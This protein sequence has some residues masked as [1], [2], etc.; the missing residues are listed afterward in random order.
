[1]R[2]YVLGLAGLLCLAP[3]GLASVV[4]RAAGAGT[5]PPYERLLKGADQRAADELVSRETRAW[6][7]G[8]FEEAL[9][10]A[11]ALLALRQKV[12]GQAHWQTL[13]AGEE[14]EALRRTLKQDPATRQ[15][16][17]GQAAL[18]ARAAA[19]EDRG[20]YR[21][22]EPLRRQVLDLCRRALG[23]DHV[24]T[25]NAYGSLAFNLKAQGKYTA[26]EPLY[27]KELDIDLKVLGDQHPYTAK[28]YTSLGETLLVQ[29][30]HTAAE[31]LIRKALAIDLRVLGEDNADTA[32]AYTTLG[33]SL[34]LRGN[35]AAAQPLM[36][37]A[38]AINRKLLGDNHTDTAAAYNNLAFTLDT[39]GKHAAA[40]PLY[41]KALAT[42]RKVH[43]EENAGTAR[44]CNNLAMNL[45]AQ[46]KYAAAEE[47]L[48]RALA[49]GRKLLGD[50]HPDVG[51][52]YNNL[53]VDLDAQGSYAAAFPL[54]QRGLDIHRKALGEEHL[55]TA[56]CY[57][58][59]ALNLTNQGDYA[60]AEPLYQ[61]A[62]DIARKIVGEDHP[63]LGLYFNGQ[64]MNLDRQREHKTA[65]PLLRKALAVTRK[66]WGDDH[67]QTATGYNNLAV[68]LNSQHKPAEAEPLHRRAL[69]I[70]QKVLGD[71]H[72]RTAHVSAD[73]AY[74]LDAQGKFTAA[75]PLLRHAL[76][77]RRKSLG[78]EHL[79]TALGYDVLAL[80]LNAQGKYAEAE[81]MWTRAANAFQRARLRVA[82]SGLGRAA[83]TT[84]R[85]PLLFL[86]AVLARNGKPEE[87]W[88]R[89]EESLAPGTWDDLSARLHRA[90][91]D[92]D[93]RSAL[94]ASLNR[95]DQ[96]IERTLAARETADLKRRR[97]EL[98]TERRRRQEELDTLSARLENEYGPVAG[99]VY[100]RATIQAAL[101]AD[102]A[103]VGWI[104][105]RADPGAADPR[106]EH[107]AVALRAR[108]TPTWVRIRG[109]GP[110]GAWTDA[111][112]RLS[113]ALPFARPGP[114]P[115]QEP[116]ERLGKQR[117]QP[118]TAALAARDGMPRVRRLI[119]L[120]SVSLDGAPLDVCIPGYTISYAPSGTLFAYLRRQRPTAGGLL[121][122]ADPVFTSDRPLALQDQA[123][124][125]GTADDKWPALPGTR[126]E[127]EGLGQLCRAAKLPFR[128]L[129][130]SDASEQ[131]LDR[132][133]RS[134]ELASYRY[135]HLATHGIFDDSRPLQSAVILAR[136]RL[137]D[138]IKQLE[139]GRPVYDGR[140]TAEE[141]LQHWDLH[142]DLVTLSACQTALGEHQT[143][144][145]FVGFT[146]ALLLSGARSVCLS[147]W[148]VDDTATALLMQRFY[149]NLL[150]QRPGLTKPLGKAEALVE[151]KRWLRELTA[152]EA[153][154]QAAALTQGVARG[155]GRKPLPMLPAAKVHATG[156]AAKPYAHPYYWAAFVLVG[157]GD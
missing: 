32:L 141:V 104:D 101:P 135:V 24:M 58:N 155:K 94:V 55:E 43:G 95:L 151:A 10:A 61:R 98:L 15:E 118:L 75:E 25:A 108:G 26:A 99:Q 137:P 33:Y 30:K 93:R 109:S 68:N 12:Q 2:R 138:P 129:A 63:F 133:A 97:E 17:A 112:R 139:E 157:D 142:A 40:Q 128:L 78:E 156:T 113:G 59:L 18:R 86:A 152:E 65:E 41:E 16:M 123:R 5:P 89:Y 4:D 150:G 54:Y 73:L 48:R 62:L 39:Q 45:K 60:A 147:L 131:E 20:K 111:D 11:Q 70:C 76:A 23:E 1:M 56:R 149:A 6:A 7:A 66:A 13:I 148:K 29:S 116:A 34:S 3:V 28:V 146:Q 71:D 31:P 153:V 52:Y 79:E 125:R 27:R 136:D 36:A 83:N 9:R 106:G 77:V 35:Y 121:A 110:H 38:L 90:P 50:D 74:C 120:P 92:R 8:R 122:V 140:L 42:F 130:D 154:K 84:E 22:A 88:R 69:A 57:F 103:L 143:G 49:V 100:D 87:A 96:L 81:A 37:K 80:N 102:A 105:R 126:A 44:A 82:S 115:W 85:T 67:L 127:A 64:A 134:K 124:H 132:L 51:M 91:A 114:R 117:F 14:V 21:D 53:A 119:V 145:G 46:G 144:E 107:W 19:Q 47:L 72:P